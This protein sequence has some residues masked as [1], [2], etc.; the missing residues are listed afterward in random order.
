MT[1][2]CVECGEVTD[3]EE[4]LCSICEEQLSKELEFLNM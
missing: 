1:N 2:L 4:D 3:K